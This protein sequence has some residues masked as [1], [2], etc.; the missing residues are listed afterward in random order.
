MKLPIHRVAV[1]SARVI[2][3]PRLGIGLLIFGS[4]YLGA[5]VIRYVIRMSL[6]LEERWTG[7]SIPIFFHWI[8]ASF[9][10]LVGQYRW[11][12]TRPS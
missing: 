8:L 1:A 10:L 12:R 4:L 5:M 2:L 9:M 6:Y 3:S 11:S 7:G